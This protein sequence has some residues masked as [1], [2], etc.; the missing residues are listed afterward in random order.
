MFRDQKHEINA[1]GRPD[2]K[3]DQHDERDS[4]PRHLLRLIKVRAAFF[5]RACS[6]CPQSLLHRRVQTDP[7]HHD[8]Q[9][10]KEATYALQR[11]RQPRGEDAALV[12]V[13]EEGAVQ[14]RHEP[15]HGTDE[16]AQKRRVEE[17]RQEQ[18]PPLRARAELVPLLLGHDRRAPVRYRHCYSG[19]G[20]APRVELWG[21]R[22]GQKRG[23]ARG[24]EEC[25]LSRVDGRE[26][27]GRATL[28]LA[29]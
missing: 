7:S 13:A 11:C 6:P 21:R 2:D 27:D 29:Q 14:G 3:T 12:R 19:H 18:Q 9:R 1:R 8:G 23:A 22:V 24:W 17:V 26:A 20:R 15:N 16:S 25:V 5:I 28:V 4:D 10:H